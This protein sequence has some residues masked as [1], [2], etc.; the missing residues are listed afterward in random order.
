M[1]AVL[2]T[3]KPSKSIAKYYIVNKSI[4]LYKLVI[5]KECL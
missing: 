3:T 4:Q 5:F 2:K 1:A